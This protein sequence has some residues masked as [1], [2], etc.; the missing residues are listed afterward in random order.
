MDGCLVLKPLQNSGKQVNHPLVAKRLR[1]VCTA[2]L[3][4]KACMA[5]WDF[6]EA[7]K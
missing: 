1:L 3:V 2:T 4:F 6:P 5:P 7:S